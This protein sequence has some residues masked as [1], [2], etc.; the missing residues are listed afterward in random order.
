MIRGGAATRFTGGVR[1][2][3]L[4]PLLLLFCL[5]VPRLAP[6]PPFLRVSEGGGGGDGDLRRGGGGNS[7]EVALHPFPSSSVTPSGSL[8]LC[9]EGLGAD[10]RGGEAAV[11]RHREA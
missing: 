9:R 2:G 3:A 10:R 8:P 7:D 6:Y 1:V 5:C 11:V 4:H